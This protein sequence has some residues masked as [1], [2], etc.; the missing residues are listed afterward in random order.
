MPSGFRRNLVSN[1]AHAVF[2]Y[3]EVFEY[4]FYSHDWSSLNLD[5]L[6]N[7]EKPRE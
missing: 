7:K 2:W 6:H 4:K 3:S 5:R 1:Q